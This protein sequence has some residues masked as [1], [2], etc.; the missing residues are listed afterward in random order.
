M[1]ITTTPFYVLFLIHIANS[2]RF[3]VITTHF[4]FILE[5][6]V[7]CIAENQQLDCIDILYS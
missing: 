3:V 6:H 1:Y 2:L 4:L 7:L 5:M